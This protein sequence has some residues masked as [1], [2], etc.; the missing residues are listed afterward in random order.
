MFQAYRLNPTIPVGP[1]CTTLQ[2]VQQGLS[3]LGCTPVGPQAAVGPD[4]APV[5]I[6]RLRGNPYPYPLPKGRVA[7][8]MLYGDDDYP[9]ESDYAE[10]LARAADAQRAW[11]WACDAV[12]L[13]DPPPLPSIELGAMVRRFRHEGLTVE[14]MAEREIPAC[15]FAAAT[16]H[17]IAARPERHRLYPAD[18]RKPLLDWRIREGRDPTPAELRRHAALNHAWLWEE[19][20]SDVIKWAS[21]VGVDVTDPRALG[22]Y[23]ARRSDEG[24]PYD[25]WAWKAPQRAVPRIA[26]DLR[27]DPV[28]HRWLALPAPIRAAHQRV[29]FT[30][31][32][33]R[34]V[35]EAMENADRRA[36]LERYITWVEGRLRKARGRRGSRRTQSKVREEV[37]AQIAA[38]ADAVP[39]QIKWPHV[40]RE[41]YSTMPTAE[42]YVVQ[43]PDIHVWIAYHLASPSRTETLWKG[44]RVR[45]AG[46]PPQ[47]VFLQ[48]RMDE[49]LPE[50][51]DQGM[52]T[53][54]RR[55][56][57]QI[58][59]RHLEAMARKRIE[60]NRIL[61]EPPAWAT[62]HPH[63][64]PLNTPHLLQEEGQV[65]DHC[66]GN[67]PEQVA[68]GELWIVSIRTPDGERSTAGMYRSDSYLVQHY[69]YQNSTP[70]EAHRSLLGEWLRKGRAQL[71]ES[72][73]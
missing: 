54:P 67:Y 71:R 38:N 3:S 15:I 32:P 73:A 36:R 45:V 43:H 11:A 69:G 5:V 39:P 56:A 20:R 58:Q 66:V 53:S 28:V 63:I 22:I 10:W 9:Q 17:S 57:Q 27:Q 51:L 55:V 44:H 18:L 8:Q 34:F 29:G 42:A 64:I 50:D 52:R 47:Q 26:T 24:T 25:A 23:L 60:D 65:L 48:R 62:P 16:E 6:R 12:G 19:A 33:G 13:A 14:E 72:Q 46:H 7:L 4:G 70:S 1:A 68:S 31:H 2:E 37:I 49:V 30:I 21:E 59:A 61:A 35:Q 40:P 41:L